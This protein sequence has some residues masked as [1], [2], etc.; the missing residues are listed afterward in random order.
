MITTCPSKHQSTEPATPDLNL[1]EFEE[2]IVAWKGRLQ[3][4]LEKSI[5]ASDETLGHLEERVLRET[6]E[7]QRQVVEKAAQVKADG[8]PPLCP[9]CGGKLTRLAQGH[10]RTFESRFG[11]ITLERAR[12]WCRKCHKWRFP[13]DAILGLADT[14]GASPSVQ[15]MAALGV[16]KMPAT[17]AQAVIERLTGVKL[18]VSTLER[19]ARRQGGRAEEQR[20]QMDEKMRQPEGRSHQVR[21]LQLKLPLEPFTLVIQMDAWNIRERDDWG[22]S[23][24]KRAAG[25]EP[26]RWHWVY[27]GTCFRLSQRVKTAGGRPLILSRGYVMT[28][29]GVQALG[30]QLRAEAL[31]HGLGQAAEV[32]VIGDGAV[33]I[34]NL[35]DDCFGEARQRLDAYHAKQHL[36]AVAE[37][38]HGAGTPAAKAW[39]E[40]LLRKMDQGKVLPMIED[41]RQLLPE[42]E[43]APKAAVKRE[44][45]YF[46]THQHRMDYKRGRRRGEPVGSGPMESTCRQYQCR[47]KRPGQFWTKIGDEALMCLETFWR[48]NRWHLLFPHACFDPSKN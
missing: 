21:D 40:P 28:R 19:E 37:A 31:R 12:G 46:D 7:V 1:E 44:I 22:Q 39:V 11:A 34:W 14:G 4:G 3:G 43:E 15:E 42:L 47:F 13:A 10:A 2:A 26:A 32:L 18:S 27:G 8:V 24:A 30:E 41:L 45:N 16:S 20:R 17:E 23:A 38:L 36:W 6:R 29:G 25:K 48:N 5:R 33:W 9:H 35:A